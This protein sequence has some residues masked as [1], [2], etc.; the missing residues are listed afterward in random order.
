MHQGKNG[1]VLVAQFLLEQKA[2]VDAA[3]DG[4]DFPLMQA[5][6]DRLPRKASAV[7]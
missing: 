6:R 4:G 3:D 1:A 7:L 2:D 5:P